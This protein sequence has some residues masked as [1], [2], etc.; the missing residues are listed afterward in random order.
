[1]TKVKS[2]LINN[3]FL[4]QK[5][6][7]YKIHIKNYKPIFGPIGHT[8]IWDEVMRR[9]GVFQGQKRGIPS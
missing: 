3:H 1:M 6:Q 8:S 7:P 5:S 9:A 2:D 4:C